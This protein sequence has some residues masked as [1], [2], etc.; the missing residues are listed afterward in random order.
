MPS[1]LDE[2][3]IVE[4]P[5]GYVLDPALCLYVPLWK[6]DGPIFESDDAYGHLCTVT[7]ALWTPQGRSFDGAGAADD[8]ISIPAHA[9]LANLAEVTYLVWIQWVGTIASDR[10]IITNT[11]LTTAGK[12]MVVLATTTNLYLGAKC[13]T[14][15]A[16]SIFTNLFSYVGW[17][18][19]MVTYNHNTDKILY[20]RRNGVAVAPDVGFTAGAGALV[21]D[22]ANNWTIG[23]M[24][25][26]AR[27]WNG[28]ISE[29]VAS[30]R[31][32]TNAEG[33]NHYL[34]T[35]WRYQ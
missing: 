21:D 30:N 23:G 1:G 31:I 10:R 7:G 29:I 3:E 26:V 18:H 17:H 27:S 16:H 32:L 4:A 11:E 22:S 13:A 15:E 6:R 33:D 2:L 28:I 34:A 12:R 5:G 35:R 8:F 24:A 9:S 25:T 14:T 20:L 19:L